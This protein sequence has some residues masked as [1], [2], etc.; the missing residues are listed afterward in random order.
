MWV[1]GNFQFDTRE[2]LIMGILNATPDSFSDGGAYYRRQG[3]EREHEPKRPGVYLNVEAAC[4]HARNM[5][6]QGADLIDV[7]GESTRPGAREV[8]VSEELARVLPILDILVNEGIAVSIDTRHPELAAACVAHGAAVINDIT[9]F[10]KAPMR[11][12]AQRNPIGCIIAHMQGEPEN[13]QVAP[14]Y[15]DVVGE[16]EAYLLLQA[17]RLEEVGV[18]RNRIAVDPG[19]GFGKSYEHNMALL[20]ATKRLASHGY[21]LVAAWSRKGFIGELTGVPVASQRVAGSVAVAVYAAQM[22]A[23]ILRVHDVAATVQAL[24]A[25][26]LIRDGGDIKKTERRLP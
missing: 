2:P 13:M 23:S 5:I 15:D 21:P 19:P 16:V 18:S 7:G 20:R 11:E 12:L 14:H 8:S 17:S 4:E 3:F 1:C 10:S 9:G 25:V 26:S 24:K 22:G 6:A